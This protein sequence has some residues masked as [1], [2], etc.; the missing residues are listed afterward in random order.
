MWFYFIFVTREHLCLFSHSELTWHSLPYS[1]HGQHYH[2]H[3]GRRPVSPRPA[4]PSAPARM[5][6]AVVLLVPQPPPL[7]PRAALRLPLSAPRAALAVPVHVLLL[8]WLVGNYRYYDPCPT[9]L[10]R[11]MVTCMPL[12]RRIHSLPHADDSTHD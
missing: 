5:P 8:R 9:R 2:T 4:R 1:H 3:H 7:A 11:Y 10:A 12:E 6:T